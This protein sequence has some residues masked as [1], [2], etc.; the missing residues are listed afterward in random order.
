MRRS[1]SIMLAAGLTAVVLAPSAAPAAPAPLP[2]AGRVSNSNE[3]F[4][5]NN[6]GNRMEQISLKTFHIEAK[7][8]QKT[9]AIGDTVKIKANVT[10]PAKEDPLGQ[11]IPMDRPYVT[12][13]EEI[14]V[15]VGLLVGD[16]FLP[17][18]A[19]TD[20]NGDAVIK[21]KIERYV[22]PGPV[23]AAF[24]AWDTTAESPCFTVQENGFR[25]YQDFFKIT[26]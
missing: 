23:D 3:N 6:N 18:F 9:A 8:A 10:R 2:C 11:G 1:F 21:I 19:V 14:N 26:R 25:P 4:L 15:G 17:G 22:K 12:P 13:A 16:V 7:P 5:R 20:E 24:Y